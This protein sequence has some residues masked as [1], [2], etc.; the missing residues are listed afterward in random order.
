MV[1]ETTGSFSNAEFIS[2][3]LSYKSTK[4]SKRSY[5]GIRRVPGGIFAFSASIILLTS[6]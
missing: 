3:L 2:F 5:S 1:L 4:V 6:F